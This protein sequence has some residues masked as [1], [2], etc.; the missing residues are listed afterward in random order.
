M[1]ALSNNRNALGWISFDAQKVITG[2]ETELG[3]T[4]DKAYK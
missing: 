1:G 3:V 2:S 4:V